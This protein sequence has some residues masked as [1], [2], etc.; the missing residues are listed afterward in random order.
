MNTCLHLK[1]ELC[2]QNTNPT[3]NQN[4][5]PFNENT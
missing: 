1:K 4:S 3:T 2:E 5:A